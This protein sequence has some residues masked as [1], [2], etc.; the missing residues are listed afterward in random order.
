MSIY[1]ENQTLHQFKTIRELTPDQLALTEVKGNEVATLIACDKMRY[2]KVGQKFIEADLVESGQVLEQRLNAPEAVKGIEAEFVKEDNALKTVIAEVVEEYDD[3]E[4]SFTVV[5]DPKKSKK[6]LD[7][8]ILATIEIEQ[9][10]NIAR[11]DQALGLINMFMYLKKGKDRKEIKH[12][13]KNF[14]V[15]EESY[16]INVTCVEMGELEQTIL[17]SL[18]MLARQQNAHE[19]LK[20]G[21]DVHKL[22]LDKKG[23]DDLFAIVKTGWTELYKILRYKKSQANKL[24]IEKAIT[25]LTM[26]V[27]HEK[28]S[29]T[30]K[31]R[32]SHLISQTIS[33]GHNSIEIALNYRLTKTLL[34]PGQPGTGGYTKV[35]MVDHMTL[36][37]GVERLLHTFLCCWGGQRTD[38][39]N[40]GMEKLIERFYGKV[41]DNT[42]ERYRQRNEILIGLRKIHVFGDF[43]EKKMPILGW[44][45]VQK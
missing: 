4:N 8:K 20:R 16:A 36:K 41:S 17:L 27:V 32:R 11:H 3:S 39:S 15:G 44:L 30:K 21:K 26:A 28:N 10:Q 19:N 29:K 6:K 43:K 24:T 13:T 5:P 34:A 33:D 7:K 40:V 14:K 12:P 38:I 35:N 18:M 2:E 22:V 45:K 9:K 31:E 37:R 23:S 25:R 42:V 1:S